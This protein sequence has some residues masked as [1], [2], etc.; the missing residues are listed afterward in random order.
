[1]DSKSDS[2]FLRII[3]PETIP[4]LT[5]STISIIIYY[6]HINHHDN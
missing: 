3:F 2:W 4:F 1:M 6:F 5:I